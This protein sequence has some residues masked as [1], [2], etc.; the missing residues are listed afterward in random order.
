MKPSPLSSAMKTTGEG[1]A[2]C[3]AV[4]GIAVTV[5]VG[6]PTAFALAVTEDNYYGYG[7]IAMMVI[8]IIWLVIRNV[9]DEDDADDFLRA[10]GSKK[11]G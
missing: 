1:I 10:V 3:T 2:A 4:S 9:F 11:R 7:A 6:I 8:A 5:F